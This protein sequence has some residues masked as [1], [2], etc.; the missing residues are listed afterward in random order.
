MPTDQPGLFSTPK[1]T[2]ATKPP[3]PSAAT[4]TA[5]YVDAYRRAH[6]GG[7]PLKADIGR[8]ARDAKAI[9]GRGEAGPD[10]LAAAATAMGAGPYANLGMA[11]KIHRDRGNPARKGMARATPHSDP[12]WEAA[13]ERD[14]EFVERLRSDGP[15]RAWVAEDPAAL[16]ELLG[17]HP[18]LVVLFDADS[19]V[20]AS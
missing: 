5:A 20:G 18:D 11:L 17:K 16:A 10:E 9:L 7:D 6:S 14:V 8:V 15:L 13:R 2:S 3:S 1:T 4:V 12:A 19:L